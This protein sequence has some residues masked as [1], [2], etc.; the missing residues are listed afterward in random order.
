MKKYI[1]ITLLLFTSI[2]MAQAQRMLPKQKGIEIGLGTASF[3]QP[4]GQY[5]IH[6]G[7]TI[8][9]KKGNYQL[10]ALEY[11]RKA[12]QYHEIDIP[13]ETYTAEGG[14]SFFLFGDRGRNITLNLALTGV[15]GYETINHAEIEMPEGAILLSTDSFV[16]GTGGRLSLESYLIDQLIVFVQGRTKV[17]WGTSMEKFRPAVAIG[18]RINL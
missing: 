3:E 1:Y 11:A 15:L 4:S 18:L 16:Y 12:H 13:Q 9:G 8:N 10:Y 17:L 14:Y 6:L 7:H 5:H 2:S